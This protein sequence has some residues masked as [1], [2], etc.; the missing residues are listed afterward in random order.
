MCFTVL[1]R[2]WGNN[3]WDIPLWATAVWDW[4]TGIVLH[5]PRWW[6]WWLWW[7]LWWW[8]KLALG[9][10]IQSQDVK[11]G[12]RLRRGT[13]YGRGQPGV[14]GGRAGVQGRAEVGP[15]S[16]WATQ[17]GHVDPVHGQRRK[18]AKN[19]SKKSKGEGKRGRRN[20]FL[21]EYT[22]NFD[23]KVIWE[24]L[25][26]V[27]KNRKCDLDRDKYKKKQS[28]ALQI[29]VPG[30][31]KKK[32]DSGFQAPGVSSGSHIASRLWGGTGIRLKLK[33][34]NKSKRSDY[35]GLPPH[36]PTW[37]HHYWQVIFD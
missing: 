12:A 16:R 8:R 11:L 25:W 34:G 30:E 7:W 18:V 6:W 5:G 28:W 33:T 22:L 10:G 1:I 36:E 13:V 17:E 35:K 19:K 15:T 31:K 14:S 27:K 3:C 23:P 37:F 32:M 9:R 21:I 20:T 2:Q 24:K 4:Y 26:W 29:N